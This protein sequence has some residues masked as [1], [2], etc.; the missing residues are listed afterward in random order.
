MNLIC[1][2]QFCGHLA[3]RNGI[4][5][6]HNREARR[7]AQPKVKARKVR[8]AKVSDE[9]KDRLAA[10]YPIR[11][12]FLK[13]NPYC[14]AHSVCFPARSSKEL[15]TDIHHKKGRE[16]DLLYDVRFWIPVCRAC[17]SVITIESEWAYNEGLSLS[18][19]QI[20]TV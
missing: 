13:E 9:Q 17:H 19:H 18:R 20:E 11:D 5:G 4:C 8:I 16:G 12:L 7:A 1:S 14:L 6:R 2:I 15:A 3:E 10:Y